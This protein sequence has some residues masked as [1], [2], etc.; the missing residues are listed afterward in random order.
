MSVTD[1]EIEHFEGTLQYMQQIKALLFK[2]YPFKFGQC[3]TYNYFLNFF[4]L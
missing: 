2:F 3:L 4:V 1:A